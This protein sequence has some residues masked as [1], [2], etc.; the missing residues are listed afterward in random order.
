MIRRAILL[1]ATLLTT[2]AAPAFP[3]LAM[4]TPFGSPPA[5]GEHSAF[6]PAPVPNPDLAAPRGGKDRGNG[7]SVTPSFFHQESTYQGEGFLRGSTYEGDQ[8]RRLRP[9]P[10][11][12]LK[13]PLQ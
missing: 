7:P 10:G 12:D 11:L 6:V 2:G 5:S 9:S 8:E 4:V 1:W 3:P 13:L